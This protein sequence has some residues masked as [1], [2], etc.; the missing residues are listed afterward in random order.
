M[1]FIKHQI[2][3]VYNVVNNVALVVMYQLVYLAIIKFLEIITHFI[4]LI[5][6]VSLYALMD[7]IHQNQMELVVT[8]V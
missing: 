6:L 7:I 5:H 8:N 3:Y 2:I 1:D 4:F